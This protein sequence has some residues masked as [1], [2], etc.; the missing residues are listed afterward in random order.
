MNE[1]DLS[2]GDMSDMSNEEDYDDDD[3]GREEDC[4]E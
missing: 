2:V 4:D 1:E 3:S